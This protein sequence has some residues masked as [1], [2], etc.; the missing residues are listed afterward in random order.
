MAKQIY[1]K[2]IQNSKYRVEQAERVRRWKA[3]HPEETNTHYRLSQRKRQ[4]IP[5]LAHKF[6]AR[7][8]LRNALRR[9]EITR[10]QFCESCGFAQ[11]IQGHHPDYGKPL[12]VKWLCGACHRAEHQK[13]K[14]GQ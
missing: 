2:R 4:H 9:G 11:G 3:A 5:A 1:A 6:T 8:L 12:E 14:G 13:A 7:Q 10:P